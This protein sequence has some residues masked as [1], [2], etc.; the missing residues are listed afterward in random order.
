MLDESTYGLS[1]GKYPFY[2]TYLT[3]S[4]ESVLSREGFFK[5][6][7]KPANPGKARNVANPPDYSVYYQ[8]DGVGDF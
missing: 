5:H 3:V 2:S 6:F 1:N 8:A 4:A 7:S